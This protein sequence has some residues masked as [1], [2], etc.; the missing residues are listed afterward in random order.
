MPLT[1]RGRCPRTELDEL[2]AWLGL[3]AWSLEGAARPAGRTR[4]RPKARQ[5]GRLLPPAD[6]QGNENKTPFWLWTNERWGFARSKQ[7]SGCALSCEKLSGPRARAVRLEWCFKN[8]NQF[9]GPPTLDAWSTPTN[10]YA[11]YY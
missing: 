11:T 6:G 1:V 8:G 4:R 5:A 7:V 3:C 9:S 2:D 10:H